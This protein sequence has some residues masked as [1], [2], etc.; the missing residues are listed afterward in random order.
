M[1]G[2]ISKAKT[3]LGYPFMITGTVIKGKGLGRQ[4]G[5]STANIHI[6]ETYKLIPKYGVYIVSSTIGDEKIYGMMNIGINPTVKGE[7]ESLEVHFFNF[8]NKP[9]R[10][11]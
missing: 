2:E 8:N 11:L 6:E 4:L 9:W 7:K 1:D 10:Y 5:F 3:F